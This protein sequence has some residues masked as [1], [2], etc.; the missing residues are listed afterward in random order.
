MGMAQDIEGAHQVNQESKEIEEFWTLMAKIVG[1]S[2]QPPQYVDACRSLK[3]DPKEP[4]W[5]HGYYAD[6][7][8]ADTL[9]LKP[10]QVQGAAWILQQE[11][12]PLGAYLL[13]DAC[14]IG[15]TIQVLCS[16]T[17]SAKQQQRD[18]ESG[19]VKNA[20]PT[21]I[22]APSNCVEVWTDEITKYFPRIRVRRYY[23]APDKVPAHLAPLTLKPKVKDLKDYLAKECAGDSVHTPWTVVVSS[24][25]TITNRC[26]PEVAT[27]AAVAGSASEFPPPLDQLILPLCTVPILTLP[28]A[29]SHWLVKKTTP[30]ICRIG[31][32]SA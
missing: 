31:S 6:D 21:L 10:W 1:V 5:E 7:N 22:L 32:G 2:A 3:I 28:Q 24:Y 19:R 16:I 18:I 20:R 9:V 23:E 15:K 11:Q 17:A 26:F 27:N 4:R 30:Q 14:G 13:A 29:P 25:E 8:R 12:G